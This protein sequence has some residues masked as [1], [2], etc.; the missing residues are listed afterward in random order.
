MAGARPVHR[1]DPDPR[2]GRGDDRDP[3]RAG[4]PPA[5]HHPRHRRGRRRKATPARWSS[6]RPPPRRPPG[7]TASARPPPPLSPRAGWRLRGIRRRRGAE[8]GFVLSDHADWP[9]LND[10]IRATGASRVFVTHGYTAVF[11]R[12]LRNA[13]LRRRHRR[14]RM[15][16]RVLRRARGRRGRRMTPVALRPAP[17]CGAHGWHST[18]T[19]R[20]CHFLFPNILGGAG[21]DS[22]P[23]TRAMK[24]FARLFAALDATTKT[25][26]RPRRWPPTSAKPPRRTASGPSPCCR[27][28]A[29]S[30]P[31]MPRSCGHGQPRRQNCR[32]G[33][34]RKPIPSSAIW[35]RRSPSSCRHRHAT[36]RPPSASTC[37]P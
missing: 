21:A 5:R 14:D 35:P 3:A 15:G 20:C 11:R 34:S 1:P 10:A 28:V 30:A 12:W 7:P 32:S 22:P 33:C 16:R 19:R 37:R 4:L 24:R 13:R 23:A 31:S 26:P 25:S 36:P 8:R 6:P 9:G 29:R 17:P 2:R 18:G 27:A